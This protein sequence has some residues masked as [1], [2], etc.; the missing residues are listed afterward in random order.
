MVERK[1]I[2]YQ[3]VR[4]VKGRLRIN[5]HK[6]HLLRNILCTL[7]YRH[8]TSMLDYNHCNIFWYNSRICRSLHNFHNNVHYIHRMCRFPLNLLLY[9]IF[10]SVETLFYCVFN[11]HASSNFWRNQ[12]IC[13]S[14]HVHNI[15]RMS[16]LSCNFHR[17]VL[18][19]LRI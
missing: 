3:E 6:F 14:L 18:R 5:N 13:R 1:P 12:R 9:Y 19:K 15:H 8:G 2:Y 4:E 10:F 17:S 11:N 16:L 7:M